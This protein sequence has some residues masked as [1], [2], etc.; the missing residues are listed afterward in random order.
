MLLVA[1]AVTAKRQ[2]CTSPSAGTVEAGPTCDRTHSLFA[3]VQ[4]VQ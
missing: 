3:T 2:A 4:K 1:F